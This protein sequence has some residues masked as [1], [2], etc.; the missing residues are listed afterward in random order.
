M[1][2]SSCLN[3][4]D[5]EK[6][7]C[8]KYGS[9]KDSLERLKCLENT[10]VDHVEGIPEDEVSLEDVPGLATD[11]DNVEEVENIRIY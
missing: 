11:P 2:S 6:I 3:G 9:C 4:S 5:D 10:D 1:A 7:K 8:I